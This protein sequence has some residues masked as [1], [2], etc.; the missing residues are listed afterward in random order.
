VDGSTSAIAAPAT[1]SNWP[2]RR[3][4]QGRCW[5][6]IAGFAQATLAEAPI[7]AEYEAD[8]R[9][10]DGFVLR[11]GKVNAVRTMEIT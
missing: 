10:W 1:D 11:V 7:Q 8:I 5:V 6:Y 2:Q 4:P 9:S 3:I